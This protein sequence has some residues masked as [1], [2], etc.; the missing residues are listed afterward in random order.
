MHGEA[1]DG[2]AEDEGAVAAGDRRW[3]R[4]WGFGEALPCA[5]VFRMGW[6]ALRTGCLVVVDL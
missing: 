2:S 4:V 6:I 5:R 3:A 1:P